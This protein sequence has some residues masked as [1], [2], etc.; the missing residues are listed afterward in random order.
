MAEITGLENIPFTSA[1]K[2]EENPSGIN[3]DAPTGQFLLMFNEEVAALLPKSITE[4]GNSIDKSESPVGN[5]FPIVNLT[6]NGNTEDENLLVEV[7][8][9][10]VKEKN[11]DSKDSK[12]IEL[13][14]FIDANP[15]SLIFN[16]MSASYL[17]LFDLQNGVE[18]QLPSLDVEPGTLPIIDNS[19]HNA[20]MNGKEFNL[21][22]L[23]ETPKLMSVDTTTDILNKNQKIPEKIDLEQP[24]AQNKILNEVDGINEVNQKSI[25][26]E[27][28]SELKV[29]KESIP[30][31][32]IKKKDFSEIEVVPQIESEE[33][34]EIKSQV[35]I[36]SQPVQSLLDKS[37]VG[38]NIAGSSLVNKT[39]EQEN[40]NRLSDTISHE[41]T[42]LSE[43]ESSTFKLTLRPESLGEL[44]VVLDVKDGK[45]SAKFLVETD[46]VKEL[47][48]SNLTNLQ[49]SL[50]KHNVVLSK[51]EV[52]LNLPNNNFS[53]FDGNLN[54]RQNQQQQEKFFNTGKLAQQYQLKDEYEETK[55][56]NITDS[57]DILV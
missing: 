27:E 16:D 39:F 11:T 9:S 38:K 47:I 24:L 35:Q 42:N 32:I 14:Q 12:E 56:V 37:I 25:A 15:H 49:E 7:D 48:Q 46:K 50:S 53:S 29:S 4:D 55:Q 51:S 2:L 22:T 19:N 10:L 5:D 26:P 8:K 57:V 43:K 3:F 33:P 28:K 6:E 30:V 20:G 52:S 36:L 44:D 23:E 31:E 1:I 21:S 40:I 13:S 34:N 17:N 45:I 54:H 18:N 41:I